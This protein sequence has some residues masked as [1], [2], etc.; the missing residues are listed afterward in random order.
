MK[1]TKI[2]KTSVPFREALS[3]YL[4]KLDN[5]TLTRLPFTSPAEPFHYIVIFSDWSGRV[6]SGNNT[7]TRVND[8]VITSFID[9]K[10]LK[11]IIRKGMSNDN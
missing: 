6:C 10:E 7:S 1:L 5:D 9:R 3:M 4:S 2:E 11:K 8:K